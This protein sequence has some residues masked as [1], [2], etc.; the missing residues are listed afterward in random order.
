MYENDIYRGL[1]RE[2]MSS[3]MHVYVHV[4]VLAYVHVCGH[5]HVHSL[6]FVHFLF[7]VQAKTLSSKVCGVGA[8]C[9][10]AV[11]PR[12]RILC[13]RYSVPSKAQ[14]L[15]PH[16]VGEGPELNEDQHRPF[17]HGKKHRRSP[18]TAILDSERS[19]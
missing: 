4:H 13:S 6:A 10:K 17:V 12:F 8:C 18:F 3:G 7:A 5:V 11:S 1:A 9:Y 16:H 15:Y 2:R 19:Y 14:N